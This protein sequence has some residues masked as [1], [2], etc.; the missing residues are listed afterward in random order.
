M[1]MVD[2]LLIDNSNIFIGLNRFSTPSSRFSRLPVRFD[3]IKFTKTFCD[4]DKLVEKILVGS[5]PP[6]NDNFWLFMINKGFTVETFERTPNGEKAVDTELVAQ[7]LDA[8]EKYNEPGRLVLMSGDYDML[9][10]VK[11]AHSRG[12]KVIVWTWKDS[13]NTSYKKSAY[14]DSVLFIDDI[15]DDYVFFEPTENNGYRETLGQRTHREEKERIALQ[16]KQEQQRI[17]LREKQERERIKQAEQKAQKKSDKKKVLVGIGGAA[18][19]LIS[20]ALLISKK[21][22]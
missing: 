5:T 20:G 21:N 3:Y 4:N 6:P 1:T 19:L 9:P 12:W 7:G 2:I 8:I 16:E 10:L 14:I 13:I 17:A 22:N 11:R 18:A 15:Q